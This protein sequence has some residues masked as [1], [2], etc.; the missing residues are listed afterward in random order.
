M[1]RKTLATYNSPDHL[2]RAD[3]EDIATYLDVMAPHLR[4][5]ES[6]PAEDA[7][8]LAVR[9]ARDIEGIARSAR[10]SAASPRTYRN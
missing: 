10:R 9:Y 1:A 7:Q 4:E 8:T 5:L 2:L 6:M 3:M